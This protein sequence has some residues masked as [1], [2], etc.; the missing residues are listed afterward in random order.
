MKIIVNFID[1]V[2]RNP[3]DEQILKDIKNSVKDFCSKFPLYE[4]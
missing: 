2:L 1:K 3:D 4:D